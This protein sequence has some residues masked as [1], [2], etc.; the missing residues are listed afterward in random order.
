MAALGMQQRQSLALQQVLSPQ[1]QQSLL[2]LQTPLL[3]LRNLVQQEME[4]NPVLEELPEDSGANERSEAEASAD[5][6]FKDEFQKLA[7]LDEEWRDYMAQSASSNFDGRRIS[8]EADEKRQFLF[9]SIPVQETLQQNLIAQLNQTVLS[10]DDRKTAELIIG[11][12]DDVGFLQSTTEEMALNSGIPQD[13]F[14]RVLGLVQTFYPAGVGARDL[15][16]CLLIQLRR[17]GK[18]HS[19]EHR[20]V[21]EHMDDLGRHRFLEIARRM[22]ISVED[23]Q[24]A[25]DNIARLNPRPGQVFAAA[26]QNYVLPDVIVEKVDGEYQIAFNNEQIPHL[27]ISNLYKDI[28]ASGDAQSSDVKDY[29]RDKIRSGKFLIRSIHQR[30]QTIMNIAQQIVSRQRDFLEHGPSHLK[31]MTMAEVAEAVGVHETTVSRAV[32]GK[33][34]ATPQGV[35]EMKYFFTSGYQTATGESLSNTSVKQAILD[36]VKHES[37]S[38]PLSDHEIVEI[39]SERGIPIARRTVAK[40]R[41]ELNILPS[42]MRR[43][44]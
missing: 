9:D 15:R 20:I 8:K 4:T 36:L 31:A 42:H 24:K 40:Y 5:E 10:A 26:P 3:E 38:A 43:K 12:I 34:M 6:N 2:I 29:I 33:Y 1:L 37:G 35:F 25:A 16:E 32:S 21:S 22:A 28:I 11:N 27:R 44:Y 17:Q 18:E 19:L 30:Q 41:T 23:V 14:E 13:E 7:S 39:L